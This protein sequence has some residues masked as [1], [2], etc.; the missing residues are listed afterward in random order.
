MK[1]HYAKKG[2]FLHNNQLALC[3]KQE[4]FDTVSDDFKKCDCKQCIDA[5]PIHKKIWHSQN[6]AN[7]KN[8]Q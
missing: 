3:G 4:K 6:K 8:L 5:M 2:S 1:T 7:Y